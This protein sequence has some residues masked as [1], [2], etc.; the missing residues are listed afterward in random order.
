[1]KTYVAT[2]SEPTPFVCIASF[3]IGN[4]PYADHSSVGVRLCVGRPSRCKQILSDV[5]YAFPYPSLLLYVAFQGWTQ[6]CVRLVWLNRRR[7]VGK[8]A[9]ISVPF[10]I[11]SNETRRERG[12]SSLVHRLALHQLLSGLVFF[13]SCSTPDTSSPRPL[14]CMIW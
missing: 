14:I 4:F 6:S 7:M 5:S 9:S 1:M 8:G 10:M 11:S 13:L 2:G 12:N 3:F